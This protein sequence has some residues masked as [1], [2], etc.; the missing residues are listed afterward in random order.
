MD[1]EP[2]PDAERIAG[3]VSSLLKKRGVQRPVAHDEP[4]RETGLTSLDLVNL[5]LMVEAE[6]EVFIP[7]AQMTPEQFR[8]VLTIQSMLAGLRPPG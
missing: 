7:E 5:M 6:F 4:L 8:S 3:L 2:A 1:A